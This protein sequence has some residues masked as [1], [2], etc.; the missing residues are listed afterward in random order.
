M[1]KGCV[2]DSDEE[3]ETAL[4]C[5]MGVECSYSGIG[6]H[7]MGGLRVVDPIPGLAIVTAIRSK[8]IMVKGLDGMAHPNK[9]I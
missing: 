7:V 3:L 2:E 9:Y 6:I 5:R 4:A 8:Y 1:C